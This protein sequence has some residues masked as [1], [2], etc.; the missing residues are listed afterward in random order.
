MQTPQRLRPCG[1]LKIAAAGPSN[2]SLPWN[3]PG[4]NL[5]GAGN[6]FVDELLPVY[7]AAEAKVNFS[8]AV[9]GDRANKLAIELLGAD[10]NAALQQTTVRGGE[11]VWWSL[12]LPAGLSRLRVAADPANAAPLSYILGVA[13]LPSDSVAFQ[14]TAD[15]LGSHRRCALAPACPASTSLPQPARRRTSTW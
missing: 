3:K 12:D 7:L 10:G 11:T 2:D 4:E 15:G 6:A 8:A 13:S 1:S 14:G 9:T 5:G